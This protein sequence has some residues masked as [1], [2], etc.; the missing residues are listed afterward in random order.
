MNKDDIHKILTEKKVELKERFGVTRIGLF[1]SYVRNEESH[2]SDMDFVVELE[3][4]DLILISSLK[5]Y[6]QD[7][8][9]NDVDIVRLRKNM[10]ESLRKRIQ[11]EAIYV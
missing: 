8:F 4:P 6:L 5:N 2:E 9:K 1:G 11:D 3:A 7:I 10:N